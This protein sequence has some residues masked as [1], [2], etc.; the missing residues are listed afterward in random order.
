MILGLIQ[1]SFALFSLLDCPF[2]PLSVYLDKIKTIQQSSQKLL[3]QSQQQTSQLQQQSDYHMNEIHK[4]IDDNLQLKQ[5]LTKLEEQYKEVKESELKRASECETLI[6]QI[7]NLN[8]QLTAVSNEMVVK[9]SWMTTVSAQTREMSECVL[10]AVESIQKGLSD[11]EKQFQQQFQ[12]RE[13][14]RP[15]N[16]VDVKWIMQNVIGAA[17]F[18]HVKIEEFARTVEENVG[19]NN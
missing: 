14:D 16:T 12:Q 11:L 9:A 18:A 17:N 10:K 7:G 5:Q 15:T 1:Y 2:T 3:Q 8:E 13:V 19:L 6:T 4:L